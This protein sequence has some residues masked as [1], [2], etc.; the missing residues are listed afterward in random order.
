MESVKSRIKKAIYDAFPATFKLFLAQEVMNRHGYLRFLNTSFSQEGEDLILSQLF[1]GKVNGFYVDVGAHHPLQYSNTYRFYL[2][3]WRGIN[4]DAMPGSMDGFNKIRPEDVNLEIAVSNKDQVLTYYM[5][6]AAGT[7]TFSERHAE[8]MLKLG[9]TL[10]ATRNIKTIK[11]QD[12]LAER[13]AK[14]QQ[15]DFISLD[16][17][18]LELD[19]LISND[20]TSFRPT[21]VLVE[22]LELVNKDVLVSFMNQHQYYLVAHT[23][24]NLYFKT[25]IANYQNYLPDN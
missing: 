22:S 20:W 24:N 7:N 21:V 4:I 16:V 2:N 5:F 25:T 11:L 23:T 9:G 13:L 10:L 3:G 14:G 1:Y 12:I 18:G 17:E 15:I 19:V 8:E 6:D